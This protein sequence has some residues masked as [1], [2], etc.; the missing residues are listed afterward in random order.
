ME[1]D[2]WITVAVLAGVV[3]ALVRDL[4]APFLA[5]L[6][7]VV[8]LL[9]TGVITVEQAFAGFSNPAPITVAGLFVVA[10]AVERTGALQPLVNGALKNGGGLMRLL[11][12]TSLASGFVNNTP[13]VAILA[14][15]VADWA[16]GTGRDASR[17]LMP[18]SF[19]TIL[20]GTLTLIGTS[21]NLVASGLLVAAGME[22]LGF[23]E[24][25]VLGLPL[26]IVGV[27]AIVV[28]APRVLPSRTG[29]RQ[30]LRG[31]TRE[32]VMHQ[33][34]EEGGPLE[35]VT[36]RDAGLRHLEGVFLAEVV[37]KGR[38]IAPATP[39]T[40][41][42]G[43]DRLAFVGRVDRVR[44]LQQQ[45]GLILAEQKHVSFFSD[46]EHTFF[47]AVVSPAGGLV[48][49]TLQD[50][51]FRSTF[52]AAVV[53]IHRAGERVREKLGDVR[54]K[55]GDT[56]L[57]LSDSGFAERWRNSGPFLLVSHLGGAPVMATNKAWHVT[58]ILAGVAISVVAGWMQ[59]VEAV[60]LAALL[61]IVSGA[62]TVREARRAVDLDTLIV[63]AASFG[64][65]AAVQTTGL[66]SLMG[67]GIVH[68][69]SP[70]GPVGVLLGIILAT[71]V[72]TELVTNNAAAVLIFP[73]ALAAAAQMQVDPRPFVVAM[74]VAASA[75]FLTP[76]GYQTNTMV[77]G[78]GGYRF[79]DYARLGTP[80]T[81]LVV[82]TLLVLV[83][84][85]WPF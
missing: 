51:S 80:L 22:P 64:L 36:V 31:E 12:P 71:L 70:L 18:L 15:Q 68:V 75:S 69:F 78:L 81:A 49:R 10:R 27:S 8:A 29:A 34:V 13:V 33:V 40:V 43:G 3:I 73:I 83:P 41:L 59:A 63:I 14:P 7:G 28:L 58:S 44:D 30:Q 20:G 53:A 57:M 55:E 65:G 4:V 66:A 46:P 60:L 32:Y 19:A 77:Y 74:T 24:L 39:E 52:Q 5:I 56:L 42:A 1:I 26:V 11:L 50:A 62:L 9:V 76:I 61:L 35:G 45:S 82:V 72:L 2:A 16:E 79:S 84:W 37:R 23:F 21:T 67:D 38:V 85:V 6:G 17:Y 48:G 25:S 47:E 54:L